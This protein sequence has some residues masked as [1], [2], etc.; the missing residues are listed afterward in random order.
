MK[1]MRRPPGAKEVCDGADNNCDNQTDENLP[2]L[3]QGAFAIDKGGSH[4]AKWPDPRRRFPGG[5]AF[6]GM[7]G[8]VQSEWVA[9]FARIHN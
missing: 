5:A 3:R 7:G 4:R 6:T 2:T 9:T 1:N 8:R